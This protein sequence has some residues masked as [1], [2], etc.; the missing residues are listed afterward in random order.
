MKQAIPV[1]SIRKLATASGAFAVSQARVRCRII[2][3]SAMETTFA[4]T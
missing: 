1:S 3:I 2:V 4:P